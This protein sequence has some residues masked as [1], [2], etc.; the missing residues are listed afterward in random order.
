MEQQSINAFISRLT[1]DMQLSPNGN[2][3]VDDFTYANMDAPIWDKLSLPDPM[4]AGV[5]LFDPKG[6]D[7]LL[8][9]WSYFALEY[10]YITIEERNLT[11][12]FSPP[13]TSLHI[14]V[15]EWATKVIT[16]CAKRSRTRRVAQ[17]M[18]GTM[19][20]ASNILHW[21]NRN[22]TYFRVLTI[23][24]KSIIHTVLF[25]WKNSFHDTPEILK[26]DEVLTHPMCKT[27]RIASR[28]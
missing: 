21:G 3:P 1:K 27:W 14:G 7:Y 16:E 25:E 24:E 10:G 11:N 23:A 18:S 20:Y 13:N 19:D 6:L 28:S 8:E 15:A 26:L 17:G 5:A 9:Y 4:S 22:T 2:I 12:D